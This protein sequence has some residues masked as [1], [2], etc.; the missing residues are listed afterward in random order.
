MKSPWDDY[1]DEELI[2]RLRNNPA[3]LKLARSAPNLV[4]SL[5]Q[6]R[7]TLALA[8]AG[9]ITSQKD[10]KMAADVQKKSFDIIEESGG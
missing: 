9:S 8:L 4:F 2:D 10:K 6:S 7:L 5:R 1:S 3:E